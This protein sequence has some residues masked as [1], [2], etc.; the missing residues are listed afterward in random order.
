MSEWVNQHFSVRTI[1]CHNDPYRLN[2]FKVVG[3]HQWKYVSSTWGFLYSHLSLRLLKTIFILSD[4]IQS[5][6]GWKKNFFLVKI[7]CV[8][9]H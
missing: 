3:T 2:I 9:L 7:I 6:R 5:Q 8:T 4:L 1:L